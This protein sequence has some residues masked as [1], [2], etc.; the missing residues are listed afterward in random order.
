MQFP[1][2]V[3]SA[4]DSLGSTPERSGVRS[5]QNYGARGW[6][7]VKPSYTPLMHPF[8]KGLKIY[9]RMR[10]RQLAHENVVRSQRQVLKRL[11]AKARDTRFG[12]EHGFSSIDG[13]ETY[14]TRVP[15]RTHEDFWRDY[16]KDSFPRIENVT[17][18]GLI[19][20]FA[21]SS[22]T[23]TGMNK[24]IPMTHQLMHANSNAV[25]DLFVHHYNNVA[26]DRVFFGK[27]FLLG[28]STDITMEAPGVG[29]G[30]MSGIEV[31]EAPIYA[32]PW[33]WPPP[34][35]ALIGDWEEKI[36]RLSRAALKEDIRAIIALPNWLLVFVERLFQLRPG[37]RTL[38]DIFPNLE[39]IFHGGMS[40][41]PYRQRFRELLSGRPGTE[42][43]ELY[44]A[45]EGFFAS[46]DRGDGEGLRMMTNSGIFF[47]FVPKAELGSPRPTRHWLGN[48]VPDVEYAMVLTS[49]AGH[50]S[51]IIGDTVRFVDT[52][53]P[54]IL[55]TGRTKYFLS[56]FGEHLIAEEV[57]D[58][59]GRAAEAIGRDV[60]EYSVGAVWPRPGE[61]V[62]THRYLIEFADPDVRTD[63]I[64]HLR[65]TIDDRLIT[66]NEDYRRRRATG[67]GMR[68]PEIV[69]VK[70][71]AFSD[72][73][74]S[75]GKL[76]GQNKVP[77][78][79]PDQTLFQSM[80]DY[81]GGRPL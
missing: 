56:A 9:A 51:Y 62:G 60:V 64:D 74:K 2:P 31:K 32:R 77:R 14:Q 39:V 5:T 50:W 47:E 36:E 19:P 30:D 66:L 1:E 61:A 63:A 54:R 38:N 41:A 29:S 80:I 46:A 42:T 40:F 59:V 43:R 28:G 78:L 37:A 23:T 10:L 65:R 6:E 17:W 22:G 15:L 16:W 26:R 11:L 72:W 76:G 27:I 68:A 53:P 69:V 33:L 79:V 8:D 44:A 57:E 58:A 75:R 81:F 67:L 48:V 3:A 35:L 55:V 7:P 34:D 4:A 13:V 45:S 24:Y 20:Y 70:P 73:M 71:G 52:Q 21:L 12:R 49:C 18:P 25:G